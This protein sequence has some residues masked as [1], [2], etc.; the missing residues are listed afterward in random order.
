MVNLAKQENKVEAER[1]VSPQLDRE[2]ISP[3]GIDVDEVRKSKDPLSAV[4]GERTP[5][6]NNLRE[7]QTVGIR[8][9]DNQ[10]Q[11]VDSWL[12]KG[13]PGAIVVQTTDGYRVGFHHA[14]TPAPQGTHYT[15]S[16]FNEASGGQRMGVSVGADNP[17]DPNTTIFIKKFSEAETIR[18]E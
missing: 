5:D 17:F 2:T 10:A 3:S 12:A 7:G 11:A 16:C 9:T 6:L 8:V 1:S 13:G 15:I 14:G 4:K 18:N